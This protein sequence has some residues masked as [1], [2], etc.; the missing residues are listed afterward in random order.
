MP[1]TTSNSSPHR[2]AEPGAT[3]DAARTRRN[4][5]D[6]AYREFAARGFHGT[7]V[8]RICTR[9]GVGKQALSHHFGSKEG[10][11]LA[12]L[13]H[14]YV[15]ARTNDPNLADETMPP[16]DAMCAFVATTFEHLAQNRRFV[17]LQADENVN[18]GRHI[19][20][21]TTLPKLY[22]PLIDR[23]GALLSRGVACGAFREGIDPRQLYISISALCYFYFSNTYTLSAVF[24]SDML[25]PVAL[26]QRRAHVLDFIRAALV[27]SRAASP[28]DPHDLRAMSPI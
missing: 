19:R 16:M 27:P 22:D 11:H 18:R 7:S 20:K 2:R 15:A 1:P 10:A 8:E 13:E 25:Q 3:R 12:V 17:G 21:S 14:A 28:A 24:G 23:L 4:L 26:A 9:A 6:A 5:L